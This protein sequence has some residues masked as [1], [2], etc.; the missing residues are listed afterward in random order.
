MGIC[1]V[2]VLFGGVTMATPECQAQLFYGDGVITPHEVVYTSH[3]QECWQGYVNFVPQHR[4]NLSAPNT[5]VARH[6]HV[7]KHYK[8]RVRYHSRHRYHRYSKPRRPLVRSARKVNVRNMRNR[9]VIHS[10]YY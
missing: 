3:V 7:K 6:H 8:Q 5:R 10:H 2:Y 4:V 9:R 1:I